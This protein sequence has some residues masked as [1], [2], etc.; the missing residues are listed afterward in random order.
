MHD[1]IILYLHQTMNMSEAIGRDSEPTKH[2]FDIFL[3][4][5]PRIKMLH[6]KNVTKQWM[7]QLMIKH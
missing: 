3:N 2:W 5:L 4:R 6:R 7:M 1:Y